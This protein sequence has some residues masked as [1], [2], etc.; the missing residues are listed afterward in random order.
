[1]LDASRSIASRVLN[2]IMI[3]GATTMSD[4]ALRTED[5]RLLQICEMAHFRIDF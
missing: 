3:F 5:K 4:T 1:M 2:E